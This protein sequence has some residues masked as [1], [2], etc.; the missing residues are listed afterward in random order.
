M[1]IDRRKTI[2]ITLFVVVVILFCEY[3]F[4]R[5]MFGTGNLFGD[6][7]DGRF[8]NLIAEHWYNFFR[9]KE[10]FGDLGIFFPHKNTLA[11]SDMLIGFGLLHSLSDG[12]CS[13]HIS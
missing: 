10:A 2:F 13:M 6:R 12:I 8:T 9:G 7:G 1:K 3:V 11:Y 5:N 4:F